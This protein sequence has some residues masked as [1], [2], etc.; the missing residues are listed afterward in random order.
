[1]AYFD[2]ASTTF[3]KHESVYNNTMEIYRKIGVNFSRSSSEK[4]E[5]A[6]GIKKGLI[7]NLKRIYSSN[8]HE[9]IIN[10]SATFSLNEI[11]SG[12]DYSGIKTVYISPFEHN[13]VY[14]PLKRLEKE[15]KIKIQV[16]KFDKTELDVED[17]KIRFMSKKPDLVILTHAS[18]VFGNILPV[19]MIFFETKKYN[20]ITVVDT[21]QTGGVLDYTNISQ[22]SD[23]IVFS[24]H[25]NLYGPSG[26]G[27]YLYNKNI[28]LEP[29]LYGGTGIKSEE[30]DMP[31]ELPERFESGSPNIMGIIGLK[32]AT[33]EG[34]KIGIKEIKKAKIKN[35]EQLN[36]V[37][38]EYC[39]DIKIH[40][41]IENNIGII[42]VT[43][44][45]FTPQELGQILSDH[46]IEIRT[47]LH[48]SPLAHNHMKTQNAGTMRFSVGYFN[49]YEDFKKLQE[50]LEDIF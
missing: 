27:G 41:D 31:V 19:E 15:K 35:L 38:K 13:S 42:S 34:L 14:R 10:S 3:P 17:M 49:K 48:C 32:L 30:I 40:S 45:N 46:G 47:G 37:F 29:L 18:N 5:A 43:S 25:K 26:I 44:P 22:L 7:E 4:S 16:L 36:I 50:T 33:D 9:V 1:M 6:R 28:K 23:F 21:A 11:I 24:G 20:G 39:Y 8:T 2:N 12:L